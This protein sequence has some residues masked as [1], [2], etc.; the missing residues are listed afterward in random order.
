MKQLGRLVSGEAVGIGLQL[1]FSPKRKQGEEIR[2]VPVVVAPLENSPAARA[3]LRPMDQLWE[4]DG[5]SIL[6]KNLVELKALLAGKPGS[7]VTLTVFHKGWF[8]EKKVTVVRARTE[9]PS[10]LIETLPGGLVLVKI[11]RMAVESGPKLQEGLK[12]SLASGAKGLLLDLRDNAGG[13]RE[14]AVDLAGLFLAKGSPV[15]NLKGRGPG[16]E[17]D[18]EYK[19]TSAGGVA[20]P[21]VVL[22]NGGTSG[23]AEV[24]AGALRDNGRA[25]LVG[26]TTFGLGRV[27]KRFPLQSMQAKCAVDL[28]VAVC[29]LPKTGA[30]DGTGLTPDRAVSVRRLEIWRYDEINKVLDG[31]HVKTYLDKHLPEHA[32]TLGK[33]ADGDGGDTRAYPGFDAWF[34]STGT[35]AEKDDLRALLRAGLRRRLAREKKKPYLADFQEDEQLKCAVA[36]LAKAVGLDLAEIPQYAPFAKKY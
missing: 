16:A 24:L 35:K 15:C 31:G 33:L 19:T 4:I 11:P 2:R 28:T 25:V 29:T 9:A 22:V 23:S 36:V 8:R 7:R 17:P 30:F 20:V 12:A 21:L 34:N 10:H 6:G 5:K 14:A 18:R 3:G 26:E 32:E 13:P 27:Q 1:S